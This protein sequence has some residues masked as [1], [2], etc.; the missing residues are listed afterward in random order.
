MNGT[1]CRSQAARYGKVT[2]WWE[3]VEAGLEKFG[4]IGRLMGWWLTQARRELAGYDD[5]MGFVLP[6][7][8]G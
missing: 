4:Q 8:G 2:S 1:S 6:L 3:D 5:S 7:V